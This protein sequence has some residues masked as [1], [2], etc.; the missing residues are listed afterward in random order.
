MVIFYYSLFSCEMESVIMFFSLIWIKSDNRCDHNANEGN[1]KIFFVCQENVLGHLHIGALIWLFLMKV[2]N[3][4][5]LV[6]WCTTCQAASVIL[7]SAWWNVHAVL[8]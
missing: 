5:D 7:Y 3:I 8:N 6:A 4:N 2:I 1:K